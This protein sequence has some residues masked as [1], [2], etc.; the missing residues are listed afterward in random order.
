[1]DFV[2]R[3]AQAIGQAATILPPDVVRALERARDR[4]EGPARVQVEA[5]LEN[6]RIA[7]DGKVP[8]CQDTGTISFFVKLGTKFPYLGDLLQSLPEAT[9]TATKAVPL[10]PNTVHPFTG[11]NP[12]DNTGRY[13]PAITWEVV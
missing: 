7:R 12:G 6:V 2:E 5:I 1:M 9:R 10:R 11:K 3:L 8:I 13:V 4:E